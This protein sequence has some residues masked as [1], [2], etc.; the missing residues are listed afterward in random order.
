MWKGRE[1]REESGRGTQV[2]RSTLCLGIERMA[3][4]KAGGA[5]GTGGAGVGMSASVSYLQ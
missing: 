2:G 4:G 1:G 3:G 5:G